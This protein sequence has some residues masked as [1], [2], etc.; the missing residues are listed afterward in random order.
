[1]EDGVDAPTWYFDRDADG[2]GDDRIYEVGCEASSGGYVLQGGDC[3]DL[4]VTALPG[5]VEVCDGADND[6]DGAVDED[7]EEAFVWYA[8]L[9]Q[10][11]FG[12]PD[13]ELTSCFHPDGFVENSED[14]DDGDAKQHPGAQEFCNEEDDDCDD[15]IDE[16]VANGVDTFKDVDGDGLGDPDSLVTRCELPGDRVDNGNDCNDTDRDI[17]AGC[18]CSDFS[19]GDLVV[20][21]GETV[22]LASGDH[23]FDSVTVES[24]ATLVFRG[25]EPVRLY[26]RVVDIQG[27]IDV[28]G[29]DGLNSAPRSPP[30]GGDAGPGGGGGGGGGTCGNGN[31]K[32]GFPNGGVPTGSGNTHGGV[33]G[34]AHAVSSAVAKG[35]YSSYAGGGGGGGHA[36]KGGDGV[37]ANTYGGTGGQGF[38]S[39]NLLVDFAG[40]GGG[41]GG[42]TNGGGGG[43][44]GGGLYIAASKITLGTSGIINADGGD[45]GVKNS[46]SCSSGGGGAGAGGA[47]WLHADIVDLQGTIWSRGGRAGSGGATTYAGGA[48][49]DGYVRL[50]APKSRIDARVLPREF[51]DDSAPACP[52]KGDPEE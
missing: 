37:R 5:G 25:Q 18:T 16:D 8:D 31:G 11:G 28:S 14:C 42:A 36:D 40:G 34:G 6:C 26:A 21:A 30:N 47:V 13:G 3:D 29:K 4:N 35:G 19:D 9:D 15:E 1:D 49:S 33:G 7:S 2:F 51:Y 20:P 17:K 39:A 38:G 32:G 10:D 45:G 27:K 46:G 12:D 52:L 43:G 23:N 41:A 44:G 24:K 48:G 50:S 22:Q